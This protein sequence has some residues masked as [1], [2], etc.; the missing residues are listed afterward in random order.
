MKIAVLSGSPK[1]E[2]SV[3]MQYVRYMQKV[4]PQHQLE[5]E[6]VVP[7]IKK[8]ESDEEAFGEIVERVRTADGVLWAFPLYVFLV[9]GSYKRFI[10]LIWERGAQ[11][12]FQGKYT[13]SLSTSIHFYDH[14]AHNYIHA[15]CDDL[16]MR[17]VGA[18]S[19][20]MSDLL[21]ERGRTQLTQFTGELYRAIE[22]RATTQRSYAPLTLGSFEYVPGPVRQPVDIEG[23]KVVIVTDAQP[24]QANLQRMVERFKASFAQ[25]VTTINLHDVDIKG[26]CLGCLKCGYDNEC[27]YDGKDGFVDFYN[28]QL[29]PADVLVFAGAMRDR[30]LSARWKTFFDR[31]FFNGH[32]P[33]LIGKQ[34]AF[35]ISGPLSQVPNL[36][37]ILEA[38]VELQCC[39]LAG[40]VTDEAGDAATVDGLLEELAG[41]L[42]R[43]AVMGYTQ[44]QTFLGISGTKLFRDAMYGRLRFVFMADHRAYKR[45]GFY[46]FPQKDYPTRIANAIMAP[47][48][49]I[50]GFREGFKGQINQRMLVPYQ[51]LFEE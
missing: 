50:R 22:A 11:D 44:P 20:D 12:A 26:G 45:L 6:H 2:M 31:H 24:H 13:A 30:Y 17:Y 15:I 27:A 10:E 46:D 16:G 5:I 23:K 28:G 19:P 21:V 37:Q 49:R 3:T 36:R 7:H 39:N 35:L 40:F 14:A 47:L 48:L 38:W 42:M 4:Y 25:E 51:R 41:R 34:F 9:H 32:A 1:G 18:F 8:L 33:S 29:K 43:H